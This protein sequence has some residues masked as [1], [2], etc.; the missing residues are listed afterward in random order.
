MDVLKAIASQFEIGGVITSITPLGE[1]NVNET[2]QVTCQ[3]TIL[4]DKIPQ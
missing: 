1:G 2:Y 3:E 4:Q